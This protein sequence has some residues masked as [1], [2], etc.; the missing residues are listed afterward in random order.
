MKVVIV[1]SRVCFGGA[2]H[3]GVMLAN[4]L[5]EK[6]E[7]WLATNT[8]LEMT[9]AVSDKVKVCNIFPDIPHGLKKWVGA[10][11][12]LR[13][14]FEKEQPDVSIGILSTCSF[15]CKVAGMGLG[16]P[17]IAT[18]HDAFERPASAPISKG[19]VFSKFWLNK[20][21]DV[22]TVL[23]EA[24]KK[25][26][27]NRL[28]R[29]EVMPNPLSLEPLSVNEMGEMTSNGGQRI[30]KRHVVL[31]AGR[32]DAWHCKGFDVLLEAWA[33]VSARCKEQMQAG[34]WR[35]CIAG[36]DEADGLGCLKTLVEKYGLG[37]TV[38]FLGFRSD[39]EQLYQEASVFVLSSRYEGF[40]LV[41]I[42]AMSQGCACVTT[43]YKG[44]Q[45]EIL[46]SDDCGLVCPPEDVE[47]LADALQRV[48]TDDG[49]RHRLQEN[50]I[51]RSRYFLPTNIVKRWDRLLA[52]VVASRK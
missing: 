24:D 29:V 40:G 20:L 37:D 6:H 31:A 39:M 17:V 51:V 52:D 26:V 23:T 30:I 36:K 19:N 48:M 9:Y 7:V 2:E 33:K 47:A 42:E 46:G 34:D 14:L 11:S 28:R 22:V 45:M 21:F 3:V 15:V 4:A 1:Q 41:L 13:E 49:L 12:R 5:A 18:E 10:I 8:R 38:S 44:R 43:D 16:I 32:L 27:G 25:V 35:L 50:A